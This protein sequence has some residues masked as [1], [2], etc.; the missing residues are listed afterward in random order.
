MSWKFFILYR[1]RI[2]QIR[3]HC[4]KSEMITEFSIEKGLNLLQRYVP[5]AILHRV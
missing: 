4:E 2:A 3:D 1:D 5:E